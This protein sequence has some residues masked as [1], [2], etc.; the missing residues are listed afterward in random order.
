SAS[1][2]SPKPPRPSSRIR[3]YPAGN[4][5]PP[6]PARGSGTVSPVV[7]GAWSLM[8]VSS[9][10]LL[11]IIGRR[12]ADA[13]EPPRPVLAPGA[14][15]YNRPG[16]VALV[17]REETARFTLARRAVAGIACLQDE[18]AG[19]RAAAV[20]SV[21]QAHRPAEAAE[22]LAAVSDRLL[23]DPDARREGS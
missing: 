9:K 6:A 18:H 2:T 23:H 20:S 22:V 21:C 13:R 4:R 19:V 11:S 15:G 8:P 14:A 7:V 16:H 12:G 17:P 5:A 1:H 10:G 3:R